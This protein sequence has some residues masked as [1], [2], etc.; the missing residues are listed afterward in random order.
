M[1]RFVP[2][3]ARSQPVCDGTADVRLAGHDLVIPCGYFD[4]GFVPDLRDEPDDL[5]VRAF[6]PG[7]TPTAT[8]RPSDGG[9][10]ETVRIALRRG[11]H[12]L[13][14]LYAITATNRLLTE[15]FHDAYGLRTFRK[16]AK[17]DPDGH[18]HEVYFSERDQV[19][20]RLIECEPG[21]RS[22][23]CRETVVADGMT[24]KI[25]FHMQYLPDWQRIEERSIALIRSFEHVQR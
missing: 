20:T 16:E 14:S 7:F 10:G 3:P 22:P 23:P 24:Y 18:V 21:H 6:L 12:S 5:F 13:N 19:V 15:P 4:R 17:T 9:F 8:Q 2:W 1:A 25:T 11:T